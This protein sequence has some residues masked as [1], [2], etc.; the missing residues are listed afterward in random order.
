M[1]LLQSFY[2]IET[3][4]QPLL[5]LPPTQFVWPFAFPLILLLPSPKLIRER[6]PQT[7]IH[8]D[9]KHLKELSTFALYIFT[10]VY[11]LGFLIQFQKPFVE[12]PLFPLRSGFHHQATNRF[13]TSIRPDKFD[14]SHRFHQ[15]IG[16]EF[17]RN[18]AGSLSFQVDNKRNRIHNSLQSE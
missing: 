14:Y 15:T 1:V 12:Y 13:P 17:Y 3:R 5:K 4:S 16:Q 7:P 18:Q 8:V 2:N 6:R 10:L 11:I 9:Y